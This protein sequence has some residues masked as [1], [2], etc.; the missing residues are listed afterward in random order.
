MTRISLYRRA[1]TAEKVNRRS[2]GFSLLEILAVISLI[3]IV[4]GISVSALRAP[5]ARAEREALQNLRMVSRHLY[6]E[7]MLQRSA[8]WLMLDLRENRWYVEKPDIDYAAGTIERV[9]FID[10]LVREDNK[11]PETLSFK[12]VQTA[13]KGLESIGVV[14]IM[15]QPNGFVDPAVIHFVS[16]A[17]GKRTESTLKIEPLSGFADVFD[18]YVE[19]QVQ[20]D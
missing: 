14:A 17:D 10:D 8:L 7:A 6:K 18:G 1:W 12:D 20:Q 2:A 19:L 3:A 11:L 4:M 13:S 16:E 9:K 5:G 15:Y